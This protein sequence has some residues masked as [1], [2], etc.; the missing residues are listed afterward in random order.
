MIPH[1]VLRND[2]ARRSRFGLVALASLCLLAAAAGPAAAATDD[3]YAAPAAT[4]AGDCG[5]PADACSIAD[6]VT[7][8]NAKPVTD[9]VRIVLAGGTYALPSPTPTALVITFAGPSLTLAAG[10][11]TPILDGGNAARLLSVG[12]ASTV[13]LD[14]LEIRAGAVAGQGGAI[15]DDGT[16]TVRRSTL[17]GNSATNGGAISVSGGA[18]LAVQDSTLAGNAA[19][20][21]G[22]GAIIASGATTIE[23]SAIV[24]NSA[25]VNG[26][27][28]NVQPAATVTIT[29]STLAGN[30][31]GGLGGALSNLGTLTVQGSTIRDNRA[32]SGAVIAT[33]GPGATFAADIIAAQ[34]G[35]TACDPANTAIVDAGYNLDTDGTCIS[36]TAPATGSHNGQTA[37]GASTYGAVLDADLADA[38]ADN[39]GPSQT[40]A[41]LNRPSPATDLANPA[42]AAVPASFALPAAVGGVTSACGLADQR[43]VMAVAGES[44]AIG[45]YRLQATRTALAAPAAVT[46]APVTLTATI[47]PAA[48][49]GTVSFDDGAGHPAGAGC[50]AQPVSHGTATCTVAYGSAGSYAVTAT[51]SGDGEGN[52]Y[53]GSASASQTVTV[54]DPPAAAAPTPAAPAAPAP[55]RPAVAAAPDRT[56]PATALRRVSALRQP[57][58]LRGTARDA[59]GIRRVR[60]SVARHVGGLCRFLRA[61]GTFSTARSCKRSSYVD[62]RG[63]TSW[64]LRLP[65]LAHG[66]YTV[67]AR[68][69]DAAGNVERKDRGHNL[70]VLSIRKRSQ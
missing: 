4:G 36:P 27:G 43:G 45:A 19:S 3:L 31:S 28:I 35:G 10:S 56:P 46:N 62:A 55:A 54:T 24:G 39:G 33:G 64:T 21:V 67:W 7:S 49:G 23:R 58:T 14:G 51:Y 20:A 16:L 34:S 17:S 41:L 65:A 70:L 26:A 25:P 47:T 38:P 42:F 32:I 2:R 69:I 9:S 40:F 12:A 18:R 11:G 37:D 68:G 52:D 22:G 44:C 61:G 57:I 63:T 30:T 13:T 50:A 60:V 66:R 1:E 59:G 53:A 6:A 48:E 15:L 8:A 29:S 5:A